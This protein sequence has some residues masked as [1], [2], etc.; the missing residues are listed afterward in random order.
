MK[1]CVQVLVWTYVFNSLGKYYKVQLLDHIVKLYC[2]VRNCQTIF[3]S[4]Y[5]T[6]HFHQQSMTVLVASHPCQH[7]VVSMFWVL[8]ILVGLQW[9]L[10][11]LLIC[12]S[13][14]TYDEVGN[15]FSYAYLPSVYLIRLL[16][17]LLLSFKTFFFLYVWKQTFSEVSFANIFSQAIACFLILLTLSFTD[18]FLILMKSSLS[19]ISF[20]NCALGVISKKSSSYPRSPRFFFMLFSRVLK[21]LVSH[22]NV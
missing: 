13:L 14:M 18:K 19:V 5:S 11:A 7:L 4:G 2:F 1:I 3:Q 20:V 21:F 16:I 12:I 10:P 8:A 9:H 22:L 15:I 6:L 17:L